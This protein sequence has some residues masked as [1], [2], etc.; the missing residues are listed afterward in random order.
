MCCDWFA[1]RLLDAD[2]LL[3]LSLSPTCRCSSAHCGWFV[4]TLSDAGVRGRV[5]CINNSPR[6]YHLMWICMQ[7]IRC[8]WLSETIL[9]YLPRQQCSTRGAGIACLSSVRLVN[10]R[11]RVGIP[12]GAAGEFYSPELTFCADSYLVSIQIRYRWPDDTVLCHYLD[13][14]IYS[15]EKCECVMISVELTCWPSG[16]LQK[17]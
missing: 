15:H 9:H 1:S 12:A 13:S 2:Q 17:L 5:Y 4:H 8:R 7:V 10:K 11:L 3:P 6:L 16:W 14:I